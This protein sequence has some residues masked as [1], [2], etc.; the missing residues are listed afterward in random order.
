MT[1]RRRFMWIMALLMIAGV[2]SAGMP[3]LPKAPKAPAM[4]AA[5]AAAPGQV[6]PKA[7]LDKAD[8]FLADVAGARACLDGSRGA[9]FGLAATAEE[10][11]LLEETRSG[12]AQRGEDL[13]LATRKVE[14]EVLARAREEKRLESRK[15]SGA[16]ADNMTR[17]GGNL[18]LA[19]QRETRA[20][21]TGKSLLE[22]ADDAV[23]AAGEPSTALRLGKDAA[24]VAALPGKLGTTLKEIPAQL[25][26][27]QALLQAVEQSRK[28]NAFPL[29]APAAG[30]YAA[31]EE[32]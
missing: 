29:A 17:L 5:P 3:K 24:R 8:A 27:L 32:F 28:G 7:W 18:L 1:T 22:K 23:K 14:D 4:P 19:I 11:K 30:G 9:L 31:V 2:A 15:L 25:S 6:D 13:V 21:E 20:L 16:Q 26:S 10:K 12:A